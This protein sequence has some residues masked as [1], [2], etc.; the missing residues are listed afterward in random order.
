[1]NE[2][3]VLDALIRAV[4]VRIKRGETETRV[5]F[6]RLLDRVIVEN[7]QVNEASARPQV[8]RH[9]KVLLRDGNISREKIGRN[10]LYGVT[11]KG[12]IFHVSN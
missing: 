11:A 5:N 8:S 1:M 6:T 2:Y 3:I 4:N 10:V 9:L 12:R 7:D